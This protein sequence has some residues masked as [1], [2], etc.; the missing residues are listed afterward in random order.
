MRLTAICPLLAALLMPGSAIAHT[1]STAYMEVSVFNGQPAVLWKVALHD[2]AKARLIPGEHDEQIN[3]QQVMDSELALQRYVDQHLAFNSA[4]QP[5]R[6]TA[7]ASNEWQLQ[8]LQR[9]LYLLLPLK[10]D[11][12]QPDNWQL[13]YL[14]LSEYDASHKLLLS[15]Q[16]PGEKATAVFSATAPYYPAVSR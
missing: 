10:V 7:L 4:E 14:A 1:F 9:D 15:W 2:L 12:A 3:W 11:C 8:R 6:V 5:C 13:S 16:V